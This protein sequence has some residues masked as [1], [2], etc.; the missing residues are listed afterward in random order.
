MGL[1]NTKHYD[2][3]AKLVAFIRQ[4][5]L[6]SKRFLGPVYIKTKRRALHF[7]VFKLMRIGLLFALKRCVLT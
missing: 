4:E 2:I 7:C 6:L 3:L 1:T 5:I